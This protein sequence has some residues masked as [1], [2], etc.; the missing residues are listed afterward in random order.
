MASEHNKIDEFSGVETTGHNWDG[1]EE[2]DNP[3]PRWWLWSFY[4]CILFSIG[5][6]VLYPAWPLINTHTKGLL[7]YSSRL[8]LKAE[9]TAAEAGRAEF[10]KI[11]ASSELKDIAGNPGLN[12]FAVSAGRSAFKVH[13]S[14]C[15]GSGA[16]GG[17]GYPNLNDDAWIW[18]GTLDEIH[19]SI[20]FGIRNPEDDSRVSDMPAFADDV[21]D[22]QQIEQVASYVMSLSAKEEVSDKEKAGKGAVLY[23]ENCLDCHGEKGVGNKEFGAPRLS[24][25]I[26]L[27]GGS[28]NDLVVQIGKPKHGSMPAW[29]LRLSP[30]TIKQLALYVHSLGGG[31]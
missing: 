9:M 20:E 30:V 5:Y 22:R 25:P 7:G 11:I 10:V 19:T 31:E 27:Y 1:I 24:D 4:A 17:A 3:M 21:L 8:E 12:R 18:G 6:W 28:M 2:L 14:Q 16:Q 29:G 13:C 23:R 26:W 15:H